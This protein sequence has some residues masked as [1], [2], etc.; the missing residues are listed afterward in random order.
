[1]QLNGATSLTKRGQIALSGFYCSLCG[2]YHDELPLSYSIP[3]PVY[4]SQALAKE[5]NSELGQDICIIK[6]EHFFLRGNIEIPIIDS[7]NVFAYSIWVSLS[8]DSFEHV[9]E[10]W[11]KQTR[12]HDEPY[13]GWLSC[14]IPGYPDTLNLK[15]LAHTREIG[16]VSYI[17]LEVTEHPLTREQQNGITLQRI[18]EIAELNLHPDESFTS[19]DEPEYRPFWKRLLGGR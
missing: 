3:A 18:A 4:W 5:P 13:F 15:T 8:Q 6:N 2:K 7:D 10:N 11:N 12:I 9:T 1:M 19:D 14:R 17:E 16:V